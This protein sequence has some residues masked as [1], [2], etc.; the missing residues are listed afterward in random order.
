VSYCL[1]SSHG[2]LHGWQRCERMWKHFHQTDLYWYT[3]SPTSKS[4]QTSVR[5]SLGSKD[6]MTTVITS[7]PRLRKN[8]VNLPRQTVAT[9]GFPAI[10]TE[11]NVIKEMELQ[12][13]A[14][15]SS[16]HVAIVPK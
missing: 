3:N 6:I 7:V 4:Y 14:S 11:H 2:R 8:P 9:T 1:F 10:A 12:L 16:Q 15:C 13:K 5:P